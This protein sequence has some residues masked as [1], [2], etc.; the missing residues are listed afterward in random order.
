LVRGR[1]PCAGEEKLYKRKDYR[2]RFFHGSI[3][4]CTTKLCATIWR[5]SGAAELLQWCTN[6]IQR[7]LL[8]SHKHTFLNHNKMRSS[9]EDTLR[10]A[11][12]ISQPSKPMQTKWVKEMQTSLM[13]FNAFT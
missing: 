11:C 8:W 3:R 5:N 9:L 4:R 1:T 6:G 2:R 7:S 10:E 13:S 12:K